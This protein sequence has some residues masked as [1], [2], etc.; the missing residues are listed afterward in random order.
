MD[1][2]DSVSLVHQH[3]N[4]ADWRATNK[5]SKNFADIVNSRLNQF[6]AA[7][8]YDQSPIRMRRMSRNTAWWERI[9]VRC[10]CCKVNIWISYPTFVI[11]RVTCEVGQP[12]LTLNI[13]FSL[14]WIVLDVFGCACYEI[15]SMCLEADLRCGGCPQLGKSSKKAHQLVGQYETRRHSS[16]IECRIQYLLSLVPNCSWM[17]VHRLA[18]AW[19]PWQQYDTSHLCNA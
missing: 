11:L 7:H 18:W 3:P 15:S 4:S 17:T 9:Y 8:A 2:V 10:L 19:W 5:M 12:L 14:N 13:A 1:Y 16:R 6:Y